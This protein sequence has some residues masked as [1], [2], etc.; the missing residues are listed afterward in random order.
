MLDGRPV[1]R[2]HRLAEAPAGLDGE[3]PRKL[4]QLPGS[5]SRTIEIIFEHSGNVLKDKKI[6]KNH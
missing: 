5:L 3:Q 2:N 6:H 4:D 1:G